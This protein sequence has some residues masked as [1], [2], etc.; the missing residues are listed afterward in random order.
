MT[1]ERVASAGHASGKERWSEKKDRFGF[2]A[3]ELN[4]EVLK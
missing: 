2:V 4:S 3:I 1:K